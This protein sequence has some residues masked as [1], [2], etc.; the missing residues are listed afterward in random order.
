[1]KRLLM[2]AEGYSEWLSEYGFF[3]AFPSFPFCM[4]GGIVIQVCL[5]K[6][7]EPSPIDRDSIERLSGLALDYTVVSAVAVSTCI[8][9]FKNTALSAYI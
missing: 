1:M 4:F 8:S 7:A 9:K 2:F 3:T 6:F 5:D